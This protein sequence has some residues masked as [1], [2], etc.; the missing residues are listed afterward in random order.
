V[1]GLSH[2][3]L[4]VRDVARSVAFYRDGLGMRVRAEWAGGAHLEAGFLWLCLSLDPHARSEPHPDYTHLAFAVEEQAFDALCAR[5]RA[6]GPEWKEN[7]SEGRSLYLLDPDGHRLELHVGTLASRLAHMA[8]C[9][10]EG[11][12]LSGDV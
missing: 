12:V 6:W 8:A 11:L 1:G 2:V 3:T 10:P 7:R 5:A 9:P 4:A